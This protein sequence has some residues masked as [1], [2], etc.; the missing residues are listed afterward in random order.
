M[1][2]LPLGW[3]LAALLLIHI[4]MCQGVRGVS[5]TLY[6][7]R[8]Q[9]HSNSNL[10]ERHTREG[11]DIHSHESVLNDAWTNEEIKEKEMR[12]A[13]H[14]N[15]GASEKSGKGDKKLTRRKRVRKFKRPRTKDSSKKTTGE[16]MSDKKTTSEKTPDKKTTGEKTSDKKTSD[17]KT[18]GE[19]TS[20]KTVSDKKNEAE[21]WMSDHKGKREKHAD[22]QPTVSPAPAPTAEPTTEPADSKSKFATRHSK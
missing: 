18:T 5:S 21:K 13:E 4:A 22:G 1:K 20:D 15:E 3:L 8:V 19:K 14:P 7:R 17:K 6:R 16:N 12:E 9:F 2:V 10:N 11:V